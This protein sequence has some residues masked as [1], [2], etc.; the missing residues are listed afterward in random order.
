MVTG[1]QKPRDS[2]QEKLHLG[3]VFS[4]YHSLLLKKTIF[5]PDSEHRYAKITPPPYPPPQNG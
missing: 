5:F 2:S 1:A 4:L 3:V